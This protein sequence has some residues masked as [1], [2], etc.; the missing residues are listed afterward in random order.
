MGYAGLISDNFVELNLVTA[1]G[2]QVKA[3]AS[4]NPELFWGLRGAGLNFGIVTKLK[5][6]IFDY[7]RGPDTFF[8]TY[9][10]SG[11]KL[12]ALFTQMNKSINN[13]NLPKAVNMY[14]VLVNNPALDSKVSKGLHLRA[15]DT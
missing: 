2:S 3:S 5:Y 14:A 8:A 9:I 7:P 1:D 6:K 4:S 10:Y 15:S 11:S 12:E 13:G